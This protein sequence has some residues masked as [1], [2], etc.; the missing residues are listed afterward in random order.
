MSQ[1]VTWAL[2]RATVIRREDDGSN[3]QGAGKHTHLMVGR[4][5]GAAGTRRNYR[6]FIKFTP[7]WTGV[8][9]LVSATLSLYTDD[10]S[11]FGPYDS[12]DVPKIKVHRLTSAFTEGDSVGFEDDDYVSPSISS[13]DPVSKTMSKVPSGV[14][15][16]DVTKLVRKWAPA[17]VAGG[18]GTLAQANA[19]NHGF[20]LVGTNSSNENWGGW[21][22][23]HGT[24]GQRP[25]L[26]IVYELGPTTPN[27]PINL[28][29]SGVVASVSAFE[30]DFSDVRVTDTLVQSHVQVYT[31]TGVKSGDADTDDTID[32]TAHGFKI[33]DEV[34]FHS[35][36]GGAG[37]STGRAYYVRSSA[38]HSANTFK[39]SETPGGTPA[40][41][42]TA[43]TALTVGKPIW[44]KAKAAS[45]TER[46][47]DH[48]FVLPEGLNLTRLTTYKW[49]VRHKDSDSRWSAW[50]ALVSFS[51]TNTDPNAPTNMRP[52]G[53]SVS[54]MH[55]NF[56]CSFTDPDAADDYALAH[57]FQ[58]SALPEG[59]PGWDDA[60]FIKWDT[61]KVYSADE[62]TVTRQ[63]Y[64]GEELT[65][66][67]YYWRARH[68]DRHDGLSDW[69]YAEVTLLTDFDPLPGTQ[70]DIQEN[71]N[72]P[73]RIRIR[74]MKFNSL[75]GTTGAITGVAA[76]NL[77][78]SAK[79]HKLTAGRKVRIS[80]VTGGT[81]LF[82]DGDYWVIASGLTT[83][84]FKLSETRGGSEVNFTT[85]VSAMVLTGVT[86]RGPGNVVAII[87]NAKSVGGT[88]VYNSPGGAGFTLP[89]DHPQIAVIEPRQVHYGIDHYTGDGW[90]ET[91]AGLVWDM[92]ANETDVVFPGMDYLGLLDSVSDERYDPAV[93]DKSYTKGGSK[94][95][96]VTIR[97]VVLDQLNR[98]R[99]L[100]NSPVGFIS[101][102]SIATMNEKVT[103]WS[104]MQPVL[105]FI[106][107]LLDS[108][109]Q[110]TGKKTRIQVRRTSV[111]G[112][113]F[114]I[115]DAPGQVR[116]NLR[117][118]HGELV[119]GYR[120]VLFGDQWSS[121]LH[122]IGRTREGIRILYKT[123]SAPGLDQAI[124]GRFA[125]AIILDNV[126]DENDAARRVRQ[127]AIK[128]GKFGQGVALA[129]RSGFLRPREGYDVTDDFPVD[130]R[131][132]AVNTDNYGSGYW[133]CWA[134]EWTASDN[135]EQNTTLTLM[136]RE[137]TTSPDADLIDS[138]P[139]STQ[140]EW[141]IGWDVP[142]P[143]ARAY[144]WLNQTTG[145]VWELDDETAPALDITGTA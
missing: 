130:I 123:A 82:T 91:F 88:I 104:T 36:T 12:N 128:F 127:G 31:N 137:D 119:N 99:G 38:S 93:P 70:T 138:V 52:D 59:D 72:A 16:I 39:V 58:L 29:P 46:L 71:P 97:N 109:R 23:D 6:S 22:D 48:S 100:P 85:D 34:W 145:Q 136:P 90:R 40:N 28:T 105:S 18:S 95:N 1:Q 141:Q 133:T 61:G 107:G 111:G 108:H 42:T 101:V 121:V 81:G 15:N 14:T 68:W 33:G 96:D 62:T 30:S 78:T 74:E 89:V 49:R 113:E 120:V 32:V 54:R 86:T 140:P 9:K 102:G 67:T 132:G 143:L 126:S 35:L 27:T 142:G 98:A 134:V 125:R 17:T 139:L 66:G 118:R 129:V 26:T 106:S 44:S 19:R 50:A 56:S 84:A 75:A 7:N 135:G 10:L 51:V 3:G 11:E 122:V 73:W 53:L 76:T 20:A 13:V 43:Y 45:E 2:T 60:T 87:E 57:Q 115:E 65:A 55:L 144:R 80:S 92:D 37:L 103:I 5:S 24:P 124:W 25:S 131:H 8:I 47:T 114:V 112:Y 69:A 41:I 79:V 4:S 116:D 63:N 77:F 21:S 117:L 83:T 64:G 94:Y 110:G